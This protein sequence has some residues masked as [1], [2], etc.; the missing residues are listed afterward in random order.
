MQLHRSN[1]VKAKSSG[2]SVNVNWDSFLN[3]S[4][5]NERAMSVKEGSRYFQ[6]DGKKLSAPSERDPA[7]LPDGFLDNS[8]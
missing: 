8:Q 3:P 7:R 4:L 6:W 5:M 1:S 2:V